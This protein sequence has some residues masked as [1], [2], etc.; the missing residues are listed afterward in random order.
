MIDESYVQAK[1]NISAS[2]FQ[3]LFIYGKKNKNSLNS[4]VLLIIEFK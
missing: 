1:E 4:R 3:E 2:H